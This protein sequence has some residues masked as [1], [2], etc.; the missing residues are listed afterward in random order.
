VLEPLL[1]LVVGIQAPAAQ[2]CIMNTLTY[3]A[4]IYFF[5][6]EWLNSAVKNGDKVSQKYPKHDTGCKTRYRLQNPQYKKISKTH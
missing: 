2:K 6:P 1:T 4:Q 3:D 5:P